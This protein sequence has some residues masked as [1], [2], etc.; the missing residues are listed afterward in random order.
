MKDDPQYVKLLGMPHGLLFILYI[1][2]AFYF[3]A[4]VKWPSKTL[5]KVLLAAIVPF[6]TFVID[7]TI[8]KDLKHGQA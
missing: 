6:A 8:L 3:G 5:G 2:F 1:G 4:K 7:R